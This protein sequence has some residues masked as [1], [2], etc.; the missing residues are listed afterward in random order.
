MRLCH[1]C[2]DGA[3]TNFRYQFHADTRSTIGVLQIVNQ[4]RQIL[5]GID[6]M[7]RRWR[8][9]A[10]TRSRVAGLGDPRIHLGSG[11]LATFTG[12]RTL[13]HLDLEFAGLGQI[14][15]G[16]AEPARGDLLD[17]AVLRITLFVSPGVTGGVFTAFTG[18]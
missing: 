4:L 10:D 7:M 15:A 16:D 17:R 2:G 9:Q 11:K 6:V 3:D 8:D 14:Q 5:D 18:V 13:S 12:L 1:T